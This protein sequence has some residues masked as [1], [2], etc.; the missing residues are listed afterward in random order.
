MAEWPRMEI[1]YP[2]VRLPAHREDAG[3]GGHE[4]RCGALQL[5]SDG[6][7][8]G[9]PRGLSS[10]AWR[11]STAAASRPGAKPLKN[12]MDQLEAEVGTAREAA[13]HGG[14]DRGSPGK[15]CRAAGLELR[16][17]KELGGRS[18][19]RSH[20]RWTSRRALGA[21]RS[22]SIGVRSLPLGTSGPGSGPPRVL[23]NPNA[24]RGERP[25]PARTSSRRS[26]CGRWEISNGDRTRPSSTEPV[27][28]RTS[29]RGMRSKQYKSAAGATRAGSSPPH[30]NGARTPPFGPDA[31]G[32]P[33]FHPSAAT[34]ASPPTVH[35]GTLRRSVRPTLRVI[36]WSLPIH[37]AGSANAPDASH[38]SNSTTS[39]GLGR[40]KSALVVGDLLGPT[41]TDRP[42]PRNDRKAFSSAPSSPM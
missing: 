25:S 11:R 4:R 36:W 6:M 19:P 13:R 28:S 41:A 32:G 27:A 20:R 17:R 29:G 9:T 30:G 39:W 42:I 34:T 10:G 5:A 12:R 21:A 8:Q 18:L 14:N 35:G 2:A 33:I 15:S 1:E 24:R 22:T 23:L 16:Q 37:A 3:V 38:R 26:T 7:A 40:K 31:P